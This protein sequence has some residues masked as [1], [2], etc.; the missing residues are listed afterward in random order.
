MDPRVLERLLASIS[1]QRLVAVCGAG[2]S[3]GKP[4]MAPSAKEVSQSCFDKYV[5]STGA[6]LAPALREDLEKLADYFYD[7][8]T[9]NTVF[10]PGL[11]PWDRFVRPPNAGHM[12]FADF[13]WI[14]AVVATLSSNYDTM[15]E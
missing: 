11:V 6:V 12:A 10:I 7:N 15:I 3:M 13:L 5:V 8:H 1:V 14:R 4:T 2:L 9:L